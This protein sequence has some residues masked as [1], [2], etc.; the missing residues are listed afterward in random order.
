MDGER[1]GWPAGPSAPVVAGWA[2]LRPGTGEGGLW[3]G[4]RDSLPPFVMDSPTAKHASSQRDL[5]QGRLRGDGPLR[6]DELE[7]ERAWNPQA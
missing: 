2:V 4:G 5:E 7:I 3:A 6:L 1:K